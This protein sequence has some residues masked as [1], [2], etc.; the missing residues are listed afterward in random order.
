MIGTDLSYRGIVPL[1]GRCSSGS[2][3]HYFS[4]VRP[5]MEAIGHIRP[6]GEDFVMLPKQSLV[7]GVDSYDGFDVA[8]GSPVIVGV[9]MLGGK[10]TKEPTYSYVRRVPKTASSEKAMRNAEA[11]SKA[12]MVM[13]QMPGSQYD[14]M[15][16]TVDSSQ[17]VHHNDH[18]EFPVSLEY[19][20]GLRTELWVTDDDV[21]I[22]K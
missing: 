22:Y 3:S 8:D 21:K 5:S 13:I 11:I 18:I 17:M 14:G 15:A 4:M 7:E 20:T 9:K 19:D 12:S 16:G 6:I 2:M 1:G 10:R